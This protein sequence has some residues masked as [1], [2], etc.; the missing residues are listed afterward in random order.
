MNK[1]NIITVAIIA[2]II[3]IAAIAFGW[4]YY[5]VSGPVVP[6]DT[7]QSENTSPEDSGIEI[8]TGSQ[9]GLNICIDKCGDGVCQKVDLKCVD[10]LNCICLEDTNECPQDCSK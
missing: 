2:V 3:V 7:N 4:Y 9:T 5:S 8:Q 6:A 10:N 1:K